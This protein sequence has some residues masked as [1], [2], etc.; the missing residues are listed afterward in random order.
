MFSLLRSFCS[1]FFLQKEPVVINTTYLDVI[2]QWSLMKG[3]Y[4]IYRFTKNIL[5][6][7]IYSYCYSITRSQSSAGYVYGSGYHG[8]WWVGDQGYQ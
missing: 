2:K 4:G 1:F 3:L 7:L 8:F 5:L 6:I